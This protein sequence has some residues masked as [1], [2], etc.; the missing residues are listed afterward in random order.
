[1][2]IYKEHEARQLAFKG[3]E[4]LYNA[5]KVTLGPK[6]RNFIISKPFMSPFLTHDGVTVAKNA[7]LEG[8]EEVGAAFIRDAAI[9]NAGE[10]GDGTTSTTIL[11]YSLLKGCQDTLLNPMVLSKELQKEADN[12]IQQLKPLENTDL[13]AVA[14]LSAAS[15]EIGEVVANAVETVGADGSIVLEY[16]VSNETTVDFVEGFKINS[17]FTSPY[18]ANDDAGNAKHENI[19]V[20]LYEGALNAPESLTRLLEQIAS[21]QKKICIIADDF[22]RDITARFVMLSKRGIDIVAIKAPELGQR[23]IEIMKDI[24]SVVGGEIQT[25][26]PTVQHLGLAKKLV[27]DSTTTVFTNKIP[28]ERIAELE[29]TIATAPNQR[30]VDFIKERIS[31]LKG[32][33]AVITIGGTSEQE[34]KEKYFRVE[35]AVAAAKAA[36]LEGVV[37]GGALSY[38]N[39]NTSNTEAGEIF[40]Y[41]LEQPFRQLMINAGLNDQEKLEQV[42]STGLGIDVMNPDEPKDLVKMGIVD[43]LA[44]VKAAIKTS[45]ALT[46]QLITMGGIILEEKDGKN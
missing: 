36:A 21:A 42:R 32:K 39:L 28:E 30:S 13:K 20:L 41:A 26:E 33:I 2:K 22:N 3:A 19:P 43:P 37:V 44:V 40:K 15:D 1:M 38:L 34:I 10:V 18:M 17:G 16:G 46:S 31:G 8:A 27:V 12:L 7:Q 25:G 24:Q 6:G 45:A 5:V 23:R 11:T 29:K 14:T 35:D 9:K 4:E